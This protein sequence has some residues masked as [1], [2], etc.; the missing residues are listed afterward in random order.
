MSHTSHS[1]RLPPA[2][3]SFDATFSYGFR[4][5]FLGSAVYGVLAMAVWLAWI[6]SATIGW[7]QNW[8]PVAGSVYAWHAHEMVFGF[9]AAAIGGFLLTAV[10]NWTGALPLSGPPLIFLFA[11]WLAGRVAMGLSAILP[12]PFASGLDLA[13]LPVLGGFAARQLFTRPAPRNL[14]FLVLVVAL[15]LSNILYHLANVGMLAVEPI[16]PVRTALLIVIVMIAIIGGRIIPAFTHNWLHGRR[17]SARMP[18]RLPWLDRAALASL[19]VFV[20]LDASGAIH[21][22]LGTAALAAALAN[23]ARLALW[24]GAGTRQEPIVWVLHLGY[25]WIVIGLVLSALGAFTGLI[26][27]AIASHAFGT[28]AVGTM[29]I[30][31]MSRASLGHTGRR[32]IAPPSIVWAYHLVT[33]AALLRVAGPFLAPQYYGAVLVTSGLAWIG[34]FL[35]FVLVYAPILTTPRVH[36]KLVHP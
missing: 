13:F 24:S 21:V 9:A 36:T 31:V 33:L 32:L 1:A 25:L 8:L 3:P 19:A 34:A 7:P 30:A 29:V 2:S 14:I 23:G 28:G 12:Y 11:V 15:T 4:P 10:P 6:A 20:L 35:L 22:L 16:A 5:F 17:S 18:Q 27:G 26:P